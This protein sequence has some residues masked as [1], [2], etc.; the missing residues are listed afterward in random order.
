MQNYNNLAPNRCQTEHFCPY[1]RL[2][3]HIYNMLLLSRDGAS[4]SPRADCSYYQ[5]E[6][7]EQSL[8]HSTTTIE[9]FMY[10]L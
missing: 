2:I 7:T 9:P 8:N 3:H 6:N 4:A 1:R 5:P 10:F